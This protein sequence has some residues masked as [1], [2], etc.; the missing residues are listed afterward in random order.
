[1]QSIALIKD[2]ITARMAKREPQD[3][4]FIDQEELDEDF[5]ELMGDVDRQDTTEIIKDTSF[6]SQ[7]M[8]WDA[9]RDPLN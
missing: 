2:E 8:Y 3:K 1:M 6:D 9:N 5:E 7:D 4:A